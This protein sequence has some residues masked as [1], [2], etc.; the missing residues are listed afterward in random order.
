MSYYNVTNGRHSET[1]LAIFPINELD[2][3]F[4][5]KNLCEQF[6]SISVA[7]THKQTN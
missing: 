4:Y 3:N 1:V 6:R 5:L 7:Q 2:Q